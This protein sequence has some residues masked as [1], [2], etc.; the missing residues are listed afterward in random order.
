[1]DIA[2]YCKEIPESCWNHNPAMQ[3]SE[4]WTVAMM[5]AR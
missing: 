3:D 5:L 1:M 4:K 2:Y